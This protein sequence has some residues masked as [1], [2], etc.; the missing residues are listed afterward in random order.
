MRIKKKNFNNILTIFLLSHLVIWTLVPSLSNDN[1]PLD[2]I[3]AIAWGNGWPLGWDKHPPL[4]SWFPRL[5]F[6]IFGNQDWVYYLLSQLFVVTAF[7]IIFKFSLDFFKD[8]TLS[9]VSVLLLE[10]IYFYNFTTPEFNVNVCQLPFWALTVYY[11]WK[12]IKQNDHITW[13]LFGLFAALGILSKYLFIYLLFAVD[14]FFIYLIIYKKFNFKCLYSLITFFIVLIPH[15]LWLTENDYIT[16]TYALNRTGINEPNFWNHFVYPVKF[17]IKQIGILIP[18]FIMFLFLISKFKTKINLKDKKLLFLLIINVVPILL[19]FFT[20]LIMG[21]KIRTMWMTPFYLFT[22]VLFVYIFQN[23]IVLNKL[24]NFFSVFLILFIFSPAAYL[25]ISITQDD[26]RTDYPG[27]KISQV[28][29][30]KWRNNFINKIGLV[31]GNEW[32]GGNLSYHLKSKPKWDNI[33]DDK[34]N[35]ELENMNDGFVLI[36]DSNILS[37]ICTGIFFI[38]EDQGVCMI[39]KKK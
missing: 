19:I 30:E 13:L 5:F 23:K 4:S 11:C 12:G 6:E 34:K 16:I 21:A 20:S 25:Y 10:G 27:E 2:V 14:V 22:G 29:Q 9:L 35:I 15:V 17:L 28:V 39:G 8:P 1:L 26:K 7:F 3:E 31:G 38:V 24:K 18:F 32:H 37:K 36:G 33:L